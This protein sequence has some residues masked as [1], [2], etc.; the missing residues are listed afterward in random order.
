MENFQLSMFFNYRGILAVSE[1]YREYDALFSALDLTAFP[2]A[3]TGRGRP[4]YSPRAM[5]R[6]F[7]VKHRQALKT[8]P[9][10][11]KFLDTQPM[12]TQMCGFA[13]GA[14]PDES[15]FYRFLS[16]TPNSKLQ[17]LHL[18]ANQKLVDKEVVK[19][20]QFVADSKPVKAATRHNNPKN[21]SRS[22]DKNKNIRRNPDATLGYY[23]YVEKSDGTKRTEFFW[24]YR[25]HVIVSK[26][27]IC[28]V[29][30]TLPNNMRDADVVKRLIR[31]LKKLYRPKKG[32][33]FLA[34]AAY[35]E[36]SVYD[37]IVA[38]LKAQP[39]IRLNPRATQKPKTL[40]QHGRPLC[41]AGLEMSFCG[42]SDVG[43]RK[44]LKYRCPLKTKAGRQELGDKLPATCPTANPHFTE[45]A[46]YGCTKYLDVT[47]DP[48]HRLDRS[49]PLFQKK[50]KER[51]TV[52]QYFSRLGDREAEHTTH[53]SLRA[54]KNQMTIAHLTSS[55]VAL[56][57][58]QLGRPESIRCYK[59]FAK[60][61]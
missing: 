50:I 28:L 34:D 41:D 53:Y 59:T 25:T 51:Q 9:D 45:G 22:R 24:G 15:Q 38:K 57:A 60:A 42:N 1:F 61:G 4:G 36:R 8:V 47:D 32:A 33:I 5:L 11:I 35:D 49:S 19:L 46:G 10:L 6:A 37:L 39:F 56:A 48:R 21:P 18:E 43:Q 16:D 44:R 31:K 7:I 54:V 2:C 20:D 55:L 13:A 23:S 40:G 27:G 3:N 17:H 30:L 52:E 58:V 26:E 29:E 14:L 12:L